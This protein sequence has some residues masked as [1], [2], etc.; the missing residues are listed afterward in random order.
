MT[1]PLGMRGQT[2]RFPV[3][4]RWHANARRATCPRADVLHWKENTRDEEERLLGTIRLK[5]GREFL[6]TV[7]TDPESQS[8]RV[9]GIRGGQLQLIYSGGGSSC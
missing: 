2:G 9:Y 5:S 1:F 4:A 7:V 6:I 8:F 3:V